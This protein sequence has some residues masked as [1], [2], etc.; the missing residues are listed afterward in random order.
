MK[1]RH[2]ELVDITTQGLN[3]CVVH[4]R[5]R[6]HVPVRVVAGNNPL[7]LYMFSP[8]VKNNPVHYLMYI[9]FVETFIVLCL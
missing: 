3:K 9:P 8:H 4:V 2:T 1:S 5:V 6:V 7:D